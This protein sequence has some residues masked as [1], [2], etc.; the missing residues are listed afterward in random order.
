[1]PSQ[2]RPVRGARPLWLLAAL[3]ALTVAATGT[4]RAEPTA[5]TQN[6]KITGVV[7][8]GMREFLGI[9]YA[10]P[11]VGPLRWQ[12]PLRARAPPPASSPSR[13]RSARPPS[14]RPCAS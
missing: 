6:G 5:Q 4:A 13:A 7:A 2:P 9:R 12:P 8:E 3:A 1:M 11:P 10:A 14:R